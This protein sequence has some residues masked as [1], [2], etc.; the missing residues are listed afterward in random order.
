M[1]LG[2]AK[3]YEGDLICIIFG[4]QYPLLLRE[5]GDAYH[6][7]GEVYIYG[8]VRGEMMA[9]FEA[10]KFTEETFVRLGNDS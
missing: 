2:P 6:L 9:E 5:T 4:C 8:M 1:G 7:V 3:I 10:G